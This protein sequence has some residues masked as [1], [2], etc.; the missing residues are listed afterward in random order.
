MVAIIPE[1]LAKLSVH[2]GMLLGL[3]A[4]TLGILIISTHRD[5]RHDA[6][7]LV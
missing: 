1:A 3:A 6:L 7:M 5:M 2:V 4:I